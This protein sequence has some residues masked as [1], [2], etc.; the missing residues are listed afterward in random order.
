MVSAMSEMQDGE[1]QVAD[2]AAGSS[3]DCK[4]T[5]RE[6]AMES[7]R[8]LQRVSICGFFVFSFGDQGQST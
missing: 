6:V 4:G 7:E 1:A 2:M 5:N 8:N 3:T